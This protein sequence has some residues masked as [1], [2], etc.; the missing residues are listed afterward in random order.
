M[1]TVPYKQGKEIIAPSLQIRQAFIQAV[2]VLVMREE[3]EVKRYTHMVTC[4]D[5][6]AGKECRGS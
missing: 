5:C 1:Q 6:D 2:G 4:N 3:N